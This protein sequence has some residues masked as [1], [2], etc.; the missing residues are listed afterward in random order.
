MDIKSTSTDSLSMSSAPRSPP[1]Y[2]PL[3][4]KEETDSIDGL[5]MLHLQRH[6]RPRRR[7]LVK[8]AKIIGGLGLVAFIVLTFALSFHAV[9]LLG[10]IGAL[11][12]QPKPAPHG[13]RSFKYP[14]G[15]SAAEAKEKGCIFDVMSMAWQ[16]PEC[17][18]EDLHAEFMDLGP[19]EFYADQAGTQMVTY[20]Q[21]AQR[22]AIS[23]TSR[24]YLVIHCI[25]GWKAMHRAWQRGW[26]MD[27]NL[28]SIEHTEVCAR[29]F[30]NTSVPMDAMTTKIHVDFPSCN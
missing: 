20:D 14:C 2:E 15:L 4:A 8:T 19:W 25:Y 24:E 9:D 6:Q 16:S 22:G 10:K 1:G 23:W 11:V 27:A 13:Q 7:K 28:A 18:D 30:A 12:K 3:R 5:D 29:V 26:R 21:V 17:F